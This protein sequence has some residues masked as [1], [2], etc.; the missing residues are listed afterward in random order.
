[1]ETNTTAGES[2]GVGTTHGSSKSSSPVV[3]DLGSAKKSQ[4]RLLQRGEGPLTEQVF[5][6]LDELRGDGTIG[7]SAQPVIV[8]VKQKTTKTSLLAN[9]F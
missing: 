3:I 2:N 6:V 5:S 1:L 8:V 7:E 9:L 4:I